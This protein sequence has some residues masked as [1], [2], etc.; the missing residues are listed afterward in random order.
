MKFE[1]NP[2]KAVANLTKHGV[3]FDEGATAYKAKK[4]GH[5]ARFFEA[6]C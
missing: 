5:K 3:S 4:I 6:R 2:S 1:W